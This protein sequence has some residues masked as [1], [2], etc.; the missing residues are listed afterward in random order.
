MTNKIDQAKPSWF[1]GSAWKRLES[2]ALPAVAP[3]ALRKQEAEHRNQSVTKPE[4]GSDHRMAC[5]VPLSKRSRVGIS[6]DVSKNTWFLNTMLLASV[7][8]FGCEPSKPPV[9]QVVT[10]ETPAT[11]QQVLFKDITTALGL[12]QRYENGEAA[13]EG[14]ILETI[15]GGVAVLDFDRDGF[16]DLFFPGGG[17]LADKKVTGIQGDLWWNRNAKELQKITN[18]AHM[19]ATLG[20]SHGAIACDWNADGFA[21]V[22]VT[23]YSG[24]QLFINQGD[25]TF[26]ESANAWGLDDK[27]WSTSAAGGDFDGNG[28]CDIYIAHYVNWSFENHQACLSRGIPDVC[29]PGIFDAHSDVI[30]FN[31][32]NGSFSPKS[33]DCG[34][35]EGGKGLG[36]IAT[37]FNGD[38]KVDIYVANDTT[39]NFYYVNQGNGTFVESAVQS[40]IATDDMGTP[41]GSMGV[42]SVDFDNDLRPDIWV[43]NYE[44]QSFALYKNDG[45]DF[46]RYATASSGLLSLGTTYV[47]FGVTP[48]DFD[49][50]GFEDVVV[51][52]GHVMKHT[53]TGSPAQNQIYLRNTGKKRFIK[54]TFP[55]TNYFGQLW[56]GRG[57]VAMD[58]DH[59]GDLDL[60]FSNVNQPSVVLQNDS[61]TTGNWLLIELVGTVS[62][63]DALGATVKLKTSKQS[64]TRSVVGGGSYLSQGPYYLHFGLAQ[65]ETIEQAEIMWPSGQRQTIKNVPTAKRL[66]WI[67]PRAPE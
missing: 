56:R 6:R 46:F 47:A 12:V 4:L 25:G 32:G 41:Q 33:T 36:A 9:P 44:N 45:N 38:S 15:G 55:P 31:N 13:N 20:Y 35:I 24:L 10:T 58:F 42:C 14:A 63:R 59:D 30:Y 52:N 28:F 34:L 60:A 5:A 11:T 61:Q 51:A 64:M 26:I 27:V 57:V 23:G 17:K 29:A 67:E 3:L 50:D 22:L 8:L 66:Q 19:D 16:E 37:D 40:G 62:N 54:E 43:C 18:L 53:T 21:D 2:Q 49:L 39:N 48:G 65:D 1:P 7:S